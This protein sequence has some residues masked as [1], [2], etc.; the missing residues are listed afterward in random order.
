MPVKLST[1][2]SKMY[3]SVAYQNNN[4]L[5]KRPSQASEAA[6]EKGARCD[7]KIGAPNSTIRTK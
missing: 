2:I 6:I 4:K 5:G 7:P 3:S 1:T